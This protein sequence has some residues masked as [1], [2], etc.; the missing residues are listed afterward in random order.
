[1]YI[2]IRV[3]VLDLC[4]DIVRSDSPDAPAPPP[5]PAAL[6][7]LPDFTEPADS[8]KSDIAAILSPSPTSVDGMSV[9]TESAL[10]AN[11]DADSPMNT[12]P[13]VDRAEENLAAIDTSPDADS[14]ASGSGSTVYNAGANLATIDIAA[15]NP[16]PDAGQCVC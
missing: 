11:T 9:S 1:M 7:T 14:P 8:H 6:D 16:P 13:A 4:P 10:D 3:K 15:I 5:P 2:L 12:G